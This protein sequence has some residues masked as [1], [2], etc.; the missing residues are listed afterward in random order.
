MRVI[1]LH[2]KNVKY[3]LL[4]LLRQ[5]YNLYNTINTKINKLMQFYILKLFF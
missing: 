4:V 3:R 2:S 5:S 1:P